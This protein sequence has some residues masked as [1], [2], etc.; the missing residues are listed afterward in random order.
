M[1]NPKQ[2][3]DTNPDPINGA[4]GAHPVGVGVGAAA[5][6][7]EAAG[8]LRGEREAA[9]AGA[10]AVVASAGHPP[11]ATLIGTAGG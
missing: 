10:A 1:N 2:P 5:A 11:D 9:V 8:V 7:H 3:E 6:E 4:S